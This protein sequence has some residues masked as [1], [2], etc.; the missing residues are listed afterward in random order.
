[1]VV[2]NNLFPI[3]YSNAIFYPSDPTVFTVSGD[4][5][6]MRLWLL[7]RNDQ[8]CG[9]LLSYFIGQMSEVVASLSPRLLKTTRE[10]LGMLRADGL[11]GVGRAP[12]DTMELSH[13]PQL[14]CANS[15]DASALGSFTDGFKAARARLPPSL[16]SS[17]DRTVLCPSV[18]PKG[19]PPYLPA[20]CSSLS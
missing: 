15:A 4:K 2:F 7:S 13:L 17:W 11:R 3:F 20:L 5:G 14:L 18:F 1:M 10:D 19:E 8:V 9:Q 6:P 16:V 12:G